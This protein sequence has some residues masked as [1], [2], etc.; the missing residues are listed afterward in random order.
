MKLTG[1]LILCSAVLCVASSA[2]F[3]QT[4]SLG[5]QKRQADEK[6][7]PKPEPREAVRVKAN[8]VY[9]KYAWGAVKPP[10]PKTFKVNDLITIVVRQRSKYEAESGLGA[11]KEWDIKSELDAFL[12]GTAGGVGAAAFRRGK[13]NVDFRFA[14]ELKGDADIEREDKLTT[15]ITVKII[16]VKPN[17]NLVLEGRGQLVF[18]DEMSRITITGLCRKEDVTADNTVLSTQI[19]DL[20]IEVDN[21]GA[22]RA[23]TTRGWIPRIL[24]IIKP[25]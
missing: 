5:A 2:A 10:E 9:Q 3:A 25:F 16:D 8:K 4:S 18:D 20:A 22:L 11:K 23:S 6:N 17:G 19:A 1:F 15:R 24:D 7:P 13:P 21:D 14:N 12:K